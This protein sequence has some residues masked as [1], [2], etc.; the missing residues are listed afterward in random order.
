MNTDR[1]GRIIALPANGVVGT[2][3]EYSSGITAGTGPR[4]IAKAA[5]G[6]CG[7]PTGGNQ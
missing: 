7:S 4:V 2:I 5:D 6:T 1:I 3:T